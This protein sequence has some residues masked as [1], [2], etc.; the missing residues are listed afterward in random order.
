MA[1]Y[2]L[3]ITKEG[4]DI[5]SQNPDDY[6]FW[7]KY[8]PLMLIGKVY[9]E[10]LSPAGET[11]GSKEQSI[12]FDFFPLVMAFKTNDFGFSGDLFLPWSVD[13]FAGRFSRYETQNY[14]EGISAKIQ[15]GKIIYDWYAFGYDPQMGNQEPPTSNYTWTVT[16]YI[17]NLELGRELPD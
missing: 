7:S 3:K 12:D 6:I 14:S 1:D 17:Y 4:F 8:K 15:K 2:G 13:G 10:I 11:S 16:A 9:T 5:D